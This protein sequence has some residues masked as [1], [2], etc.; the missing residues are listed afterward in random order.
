MHRQKLSSRRLAVL[1]ALLVASGGSLALAALR[2]AAAGNHDLGFL[3]WNLLLAW[4][5]F[6]SAL[7]LV[8]AS[9]R[10]VR[11][12]WLV[13]IGATWLVFLPN[14]PYIATDLV[15]LGELSGAPLWLDAIAIGGAAATGL[16]LGFLSLYLVQTVVAQ[17]CGAARAWAF[18]GAVLALASVGVY[19]GRVLRF[20][21]W[22]VLADPRALG[23]A[24]T[25]PLADPLAHARGYAVVLSLTIGLAVT[26]GIL[27]ALGWLRATVDDRG[28]GAR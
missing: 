9:R 28:P 26:Y 6:L 10:G 19:L 20:N 17:R 24:I 7:A 14:A 3:A 25:D 4:I 21:S 13:V 1:V 12:A 16:T 15:H 27:H 18:A 22:D 23:D 11:T 5:P 8:D 2:D